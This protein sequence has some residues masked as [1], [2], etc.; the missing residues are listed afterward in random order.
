MDRIIPWWQQKTFW[1]A[2]AALITAVGAYI[3]GEI[4]LTGLVTAGFGALVVIFGRQGIEKSTYLPNIKDRGE[5][6]K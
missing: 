5:E 6:L 3:G 2:V 4:G 1:T